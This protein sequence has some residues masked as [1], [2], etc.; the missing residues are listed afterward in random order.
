MMLFCGKRFTFYDIEVEVERYGF[1]LKGVV[2][3]N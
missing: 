2:Q 3:Q 1:D